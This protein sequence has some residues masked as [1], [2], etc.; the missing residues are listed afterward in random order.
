MATVVKMTAAVYTGVGDTG[1]GHL[2]HF[3]EF[4]CGPV[5]SDRSERK[6]RL[7]NQIIFRK[8]EREG[9]DAYP[10]MPIFLIMYGDSSRP[11]TSP[12]PTPSQFQNKFRTK[13]LPRCASE[14]GGEANV[15]AMT[16]PE[17][18]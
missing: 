9:P 11:V 14:E 1:V 2:R 6:P 15:L 4:L 7:R 8:C 5:V 12:A 3:V 10:S 16:L 18:V 13:R 17:A